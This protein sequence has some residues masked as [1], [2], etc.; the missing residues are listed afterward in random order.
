MAAVKLIHV[1]TIPLTLWS[2]FRGQI[3]FMKVR[4]YEIEA[5][6]APGEVLAQFADREQV[7]THAIPMLRRI[8]PLADLVA[9]A[10]LWKYFRQA[11]PTIIHGHTPKAGLLSMMA[12]WA[13]RVP[14][15]I[16]HIR[17]LPLL[18]AARPKRWLL[19]CS[20]WIACRLACQVLSVSHSLTAEVVRLR[21]CP[22]GKIR[23]LAGGSSNGV[24]TERFCP[25]RFDAAERRRLRERYGIDE[26]DLVVGFIGR[27]VGE[28]G[29]RELL[30]AWRALRKEFKALHLF[31]VGPLEAHDPI[32]R[33]CEQVLRRCPRI[34]LMGYTSDVA[35]LYAMF[36]VC[37]LPS[38]REGLP[39]VPLEAAAMAVPVVTT[40]VPGCRD[41]VE[42]GVT[43]TLVPPRDAE[44]LADALRC[45]LRDADLRRRHG[46]AGRA[47]A[48]REFSQVAVW[49][50][51]EQEYRRLLAEK[52]LPLP[53]V[54]A[55]C[56]A[57]RAQA[58]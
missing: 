13:A 25:A 4:G 21:L 43:G 14:V 31:V 22:A 48:V 50:A 53:E 28:K 16:Y 52:S 57:Q 5:A 40:D 49:A 32:G 37:V 39:N 3:A 15:R 41:S 18:T 2:F 54:S 44:Q 19:W 35:P 9:V 7:V 29:I 30:E 12:A 47:R 45:Y 38:Y 42:H 24:D 33:E 27:V 55:S 6:A 34:H 58:A 46:A 56:L 23:V 1:T 51:L 26:R 20:E 17:G 11:R 10:R 36:D 8:A